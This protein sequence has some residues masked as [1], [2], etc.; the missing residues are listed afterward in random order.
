M[1]TPE[2]LFAVDGELYPLADMRQANADDP[3]L[4]EWL[5]TAQ[6]GESFAAIVEC[7]RVA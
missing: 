6:V 1:L 2:P 3:A 7:A 4:L 5:T